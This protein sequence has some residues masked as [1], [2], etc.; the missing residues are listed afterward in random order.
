MKDAL[1][2]GSN[3]NR[4]DFARNKIGI[5]PDAR[6]TLAPRPVP[7]AS[8]NDK[9]AELRQRLAAPKGGLLHS[10]TSGLKTALGV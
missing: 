1:G 9:I 8:T 2:H 10:F 6:F 7:K 3:S 5:A 4:V